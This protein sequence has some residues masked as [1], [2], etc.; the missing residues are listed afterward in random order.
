VVRGHIDKTN[1]TK[2]RALADL[3]GFAGR[4]PHRTWRASRLIENYGVLTGQWKPVPVF[5]SN[6]IESEPDS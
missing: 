1:E 3:L 2:T 4:H 5:I 6:E